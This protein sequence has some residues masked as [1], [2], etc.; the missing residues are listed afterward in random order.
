MMR[1]CRTAHLPSGTVTFLFTDVEGSTKLLHE[2]GAEAYADAL[3]EH[4]RVL[5]EAF[6]RTAGSRSTPRATPSSSRFPTAA[7]AVAPRPRRRERTRRRADPRPH[8]SPH[9]H[10]L[11]D[12]RGLRRRRRPSRGA[13][14][15]RRPRRPGARLARD[16]RAVRRRELLDLGEHRLKDFAT[17]VWIFQLGTD[18]FP[19]LHTISNTNL[20]RPAGSFV[21]REREVAEIGAPVAAAPGC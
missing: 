19:P 4:R 3:A 17:P 12:R 20:P 9:G 21:G 1:S 7:G 6:T 13:H 5:R 10:P 2:L 15:R 14:R 16:A 8:G 11:L 18:A